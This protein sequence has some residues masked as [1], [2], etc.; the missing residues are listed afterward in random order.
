MLSY[1]S[2]LYILY[3]FNYRP[4]LTLFQDLFL[5]PWKEHFFGAELSLTLKVCYLADESKLRV[6][7]LRSGLDYENL[8]SSLNMLPNLLNWLIYR[9]GLN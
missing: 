3:P 4:V 6:V 8:L 7:F 1:S 2:K 9:M 5:L